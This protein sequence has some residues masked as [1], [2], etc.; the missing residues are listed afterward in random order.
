TA[1][2]L[3]DQCET[4][5]LALKRGSGPAGLA[6]M[7]ETLAFGDNLLLRPL[8]SVSRGTL[9][10]YARRHQLHWIDDDSNEDD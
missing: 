5:L 8:L 7:P 6:A 1:Q 10:D 3:D 9:E 4:L 2:H